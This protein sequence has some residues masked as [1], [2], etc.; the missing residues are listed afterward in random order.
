ME[1]ISNKNQQTENLG[2]RQGEL[3]L[4]DYVVTE[5]NILCDIQSAYCE[6]EGVLASFSSALD[7]ITAEIKVLESNLQKHGLCIPVI[8]KIE[9]NIIHKNNSTLEDG[10]YLAWIEDEKRSY[11]LMYTSGY[12]DVWQDPDNGR[13]FKFNPGSLPQFY[14]TVPLLETKAKIRYSIRSHLAGFIYSL[15]DTLKL[16]QNNF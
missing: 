16:N 11:R 2:V 13:Y 1:T 5:S 3:E 8:Y 4:Y 6:V 15:G 10:T 9:S 12:Y 14:N 7:S